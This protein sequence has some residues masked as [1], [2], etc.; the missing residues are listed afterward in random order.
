MKNLKKSLQSVNKDLNA[1]LKKVDK[2]IVAAS[3]LEKPKTV[4]KIPAKKVAAKKP[5]AKKPAAKKPAAKKP[6]K[7]TAADTLFAVIKRSKKGVGVAELMKKTGFDQ[8]KTYNIIYKLK[9]QGNIK[10][11]E[12]GVYKKA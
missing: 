11:I 7:L 1:L 10:S 9:K 8:K 4:K 5:A 2:I 6:V 12:K 3:K